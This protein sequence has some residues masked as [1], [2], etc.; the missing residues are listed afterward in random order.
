MASTYLGPK[1]YTIYKECLTIQEQE[2]I[3]RDLMA[4]AF[5]PKN[6][7]NQPTPFPVYRESKKKF[8]LPRFYGIETYG[9][10]DEISISKGDKIN[11][12]F[13][14]DLRDIQKP[15]V[16]KYLNHAKEHG[17]G[18]IEIYCGAGKTVMALNI[19]SKIKRKTLIIVHKD[20]LLRQWKERIE[21]FLPGARVGKIQAD[22]VDVENK[23]IV[24]GMLQSLSMK[25]YPVSLFSQ[26]GL[27]IIDECHHIAAEVFSRALFK[28]VTRYTLGLSATMNRKDGLTKVFKMFIGDVVVKKERPLQDNVTVQ[29]IDFF[30]DDEEYSHVELNFKGQTHY[31]KMIKKLC[32]FNRRSEFILHVLKQTLKE[33]KDN[34]V[35]IIGHNKNLL[36]YLHDAIEH[37]KI[38]DV[39]YYVG[40]MKEKDLKESEDK[41]IIIATY[42]MAEE[43]LDIK[44]LSTLI[45]A[46]PKVDVRQAVGRILR[47]VNGTKVVID[48]VDQHDIFKRHWS[49]RYTWYRKQKFKI[50]KTNQKGFKNNEWEILEN[51]GRGKKSKNSKTK[52]M[53]IKTPTEANIS[54]FIGSGVCLVD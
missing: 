41:Q 17:C 23:D 28:I 10:P 40:G 14:G 4:K 11:L 21:Q 45:M 5:A 6:C 52:S 27:T 39:G 36:Q 37:R 2:F 51:K 24:I 46:T 34:Q 25:D 3:R 7:M 32:E 47:N 20:F 30:N 26:F 54:P 22:I 9:E 53:K 48:I 31:T 15:I 8:Y 12:K 33:N 35:M 44:T 19:L 18:L 42:A 16:N 29:A 1:G 50:M 13:K 38:G 43:A 49:K